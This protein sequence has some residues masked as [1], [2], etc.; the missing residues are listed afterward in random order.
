MALAL[1]LNAPAAQA[2]T[3]E[4]IQSDC[5]RFGCAYRVEVTADGG[6]RNDVVVRKMSRSEVVVEDSSATIRAGTGCSS[7]T[8]HLVS[9]ERP[10]RS[11]AR[12][13]IR[14]GDRDDSL[15]VPGAEC[16]GEQAEY[17][18]QVLVK[19][20]EG[21]DDLEGG[22]GLDFID[23]GPGQDS[24]RGGEGND[25][26]SN[27]DRESNLSDDSIDGGDGFDIVR[28]A[29][30]GRSLTVDITKGA[31]TSVG[32]HDRLVSIEGAI[33]GA[34]ADLLVGDESANFLNGG[35]GN[36]RLVG[37][38]GAD[39]LEGARGADLLHGGSGD[40]VL[41]AFYNDRSGYSLSLASRYEDEA[42]RLVCGAGSDDVTAARLHVFVDRS[43]EV[44]EV[45]GAGI[46]IL[47]SAVLESEDSVLVV[48][49]E[50]FC[51]QAPCRERLE[52]RLRRRVGHVPTGAVM[53]R[54]VLVLHD[55]ER[56]TM[57]LGLNRRGRR[58]LRHYGR[59]P[60]Q[61]RVRVGPLYKLDGFKFDVRLAVRS[62]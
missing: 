49:G 32:E 11:S 52:V 38:G 12:L 46:S 31:T 14:L 53:G 27:G 1:G 9:C 29:H 36:D 44:V 8:A 37:G 56:A 16:T 13:S 59:L 50:L 48:A 25:Q 10:E 18:N 40:D 57:A 55:E 2:E 24:I 60:L 51:A 42:D 58:L 35:P 20:G 41:D 19:G 6:E 5:G 34:G 22:R 62:G 45:Y 28:Y 21:V 47:P 17:C 30:R 33:G 23:G 7:T 26:L 15:R 61:L 3:A 43:C 4:V 39:W 54:R